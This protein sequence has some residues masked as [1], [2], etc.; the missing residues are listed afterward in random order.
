M[1]ETPFDLVSCSWPRPVEHADGRWITEPEWDAPEMPFRPHPRWTIVDDELC[2]MINWR[3]FFRNGMP[4][5]PG[6][7]G[8]MRGFHVVFRIRIKR[9]GT[10][11]FW[12]DDGSWIRHNGMIV[13]CDPFAHVLERSELQVRAGDELE[14]AQW[15]QGGSWLWGAY[16]EPETPPLSPTSVLLPYLAAVRQRLRQPDGPPLKLYTNGASPARVVVA[17]Y[18]LVLNGYSPSEV[19]LYGEEQW[20]DA[21]RRIFADTLP[22]ARVVRSHDVR[23]RLRSVGGPRL[24]ALAER[25]WFVMKTCVALLCPPNNFCLMDDDVFI[26]DR[27]DDALKAFRRHDLVFQP[28]LDHSQEYLN[29]WSWIHDGQRVPTSLT[30]GTFNAGLYWMRNRFNPGSVAMSMLWRP[31]DESEIEWRPWRW[32]QGLIA[33]LFAHSR[34]FQLPSQRYF[35]PLFE[36]MPGG[37]LEYDYAQNPSR[38]ASIHFGGAAVKPVDLAILRLV[39]FILGDAPVATVAAGGNGAQRHRRSFPWTHRSIALRR[40]VKRDDASCVR[41]S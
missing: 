34:T 33:V 24:V 4:E 13:H 28:D 15:Q 2:S 35:Y 30:N 22:F 12:D 21:A 10:F 16:L 11:V 6:P 3:D 19:I 25:H 31:P 40:A 23:G 38:F 29:T 39:P 17:L 20:S 7:S 36:G 26:L 8:K 32:E 18:S 1:L 41:N 37:F 27:V 14:V 5:W 9:N